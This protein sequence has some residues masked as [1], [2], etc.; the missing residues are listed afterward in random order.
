MT[1]P[2]SA[3]GMN[4]VAGMGDTLARER[5]PARSSPGMQ[6]LSD[7]N[8]AQFDALLREFTEGDER[9]MQYW[10][11]QIAIG[12]RSYQEVIKRMAPQIIF[13]G[14]LQKP[15]IYS[16]NP[17]SMIFPIRLTDQQ[18]VKVHWFKI[19]P[20][21][22]RLLAEGTLGESPFFQEETSEVRL[23]RKGYTLQEWKHP[24][25][26]GLV[27][28]QI[29][30][31]SAER[32]V[33]DGLVIN[34]IHDGVRALVHN[35]SM[36]VLRGLV[37]GQ[38][39]TVRPD[40]LLLR[41]G[42]NALYG[43]LNR[44]EPYT[45]TK[46]LSLIE[47]AFK[48]Y[49][50][51]TYDAVIESRMQT[52]YK[53]NEFVHRDDVRKVLLLP[54]GSKWHLI[55]GSAEFMYDAQHVGP[56]EARANV[57][58][59]SDR[60]VAK[61]LP[62]GYFAAE[63][64]IPW[65]HQ[66]QEDYSRALDD[67]DYLG[68]FAVI[69][70]RDALP[71]SAV[72]CASFDSSD[73]RSALKKAS[74][75]RMYSHNAGGGV[76][77]A[78]LECMRHAGI[79]AEAPGERDTEMSARLDDYLDWLSDRPMSEALAHFPK[80]A[81]TQL[82][83]TY[84]YRLPSPPINPARDRVNQHFAICRLW[85]DIEP[86]VRPMDDDVLHAQ[87]FSNAVADK[88]KSEYGV[89]S[90][91][92]SSAIDWYVDL[93]SPRDPAAFQEFLRAV[94]E[95]NRGT[96]EPGTSRFARTDDTH[97]TIRLPAI[98]TIAEQ[99]RSRVKPWG[100]TS[101]PQLRHVHDRLSA[102]AWGGEATA[103]VRSD[104]NRYFPVIEKLLLCLRYMTRD[105]QL[106]QSENLPYYVRSP[107]PQTNHNS[108]VLLMGLG[109]PFR[110]VVANAPQVMETATRDAIRED[111]ISALGL[112]ERLPLGVRPFVDR[113]IYL[114]VGDKVPGAPE[115]RKIQEQLRSNQFT[116][117]REWIEAYRDT[118]GARYLEELTEPVEP[119]EDATS[120]A[121]VFRKEIAK[122]F[123]GVDQ[124]D[125]PIAGKPLYVAF[126]L[127][128][129]VLR[130]LQDLVKRR[131]RSHIAINYEKL[132]NAYER[133]WDRLLDRD[134][135]ARWENP[136][137]GRGGD[138]TMSTDRYFTT[139]LV[140]ALKF[141][142]GDAYGLSKGG[143]APDPDTTH[144]I[145]DRVRWQDVI[146]AGDEMNGDDDDNSS[147]SSADGRKRD[148]RGAF[149]SVPS[150]VAFHAGYE[151]TNV[152]SRIDN[153]LERL[154]MMPLAFLGGMTFVTSRICHRSLTSHIENG[155]L[156]GVTT[157]VVAQVAI[158]VH[159]TAM[160]IAAPG[161]GQT[162]L[163]VQGKVDDAWTDYFEKK[164]YRDLAWYEA[165]HVMN[166]AAALIVP[167]PMI[168][169]IV[170]WGERLITFD[171]DDERTLHFWNS[172]E[173]EPVGGGQVLC[174]DVGPHV[175]RKDFVDSHQVIQL[176]GKRVHVEEIP[177]VRTPVDVPEPPSPNLHYYA[178][179][180]NYTPDQSVPKHE[181]PA[182][183]IDYRL[184]RH[185]PPLEMTTF[186]AWNP[187]SQRIVTYVGHGKL[188]ERSI[189]EMA[190]RHRGVPNG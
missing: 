55:E 112:P 90:G 43:I 155:L 137:V 103:K 27:T 25:D 60:I 182:R 149:R 178:Y 105:S 126:N 185:R 134:E 21:V 125:R 113:L 5:Y 143:V 10:R 157:A 35:E 91:K 170:G 132:R 168:N 80:G 117:L 64:H 42:R 13:L 135:K 33:A 165:T 184:S 167:Y 47:E 187:T 87:L 101:L 188:D 24:A 44:R 118:F 79:F 116:D 140:S 23:Q 14:V 95:V 169:Y 124:D 133:Q 111:L 190:E 146:Y 6:Q 75:V 70:V 99:V 156:P 106:F 83:H 129:A 127:F 18:K 41:K 148:R 28:N 128:Y 8:Q 32:A 166:Q 67:L 68:A 177:G 69:D 30:R 147:S 109:I 138:P 174:M 39:R 100:F 93:A 26:A 176:A 53:S 1:V 11:E 108:A 115:I 96:L 145:R 161:A 34:F 37:L 154:G 163:S 189:E 59:G 159:S 151:R 65:V 57:R 73:I 104:F 160:V 84:M 62:G 150:S 40:I 63:F 17:I 71:H 186:E 19:T 110:E 123:W 102:D 141:P 85:G 162:L 119:G 36:H 82:I 158:A 29:E 77:F 172:Q 144:V 94:T 88:M 9:E 51:K 15:I 153:L 142:T 4:R 89:D 76:D 3:P 164:M 2:G 66:Q 131:G 58:D 130:A 97:K 122:D 56:D 12:A 31:Q 48:S 180:L 183:F 107:D 46:M 121:F 81:H 52:L 45:L 92:L 49:S 86:E 7:L 16:E 72:A 114:D 20:L 152:L 98:D 50:E 179:L 38:R 78:L 22:P 139:L 175:R 61:Q 171:G 181:E 54:P 173:R 120:F 136:D 74:Y